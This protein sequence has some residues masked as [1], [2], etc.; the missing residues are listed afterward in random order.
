M[1]VVQRQS[2]GLWIRLLR[3][4][5]PSPTL[6]L[7]APVAQRIEHWTSDPSVAGSNPVG[8]RMIMSK[9]IFG[10]SPSFISP[11]FPN[12]NEE[13]KIKCI[14]KKSVE[15]KWLRACY[16]EKDFLRYAYFTRSE[17]NVFTC[18]VM[19]TN[20]KLTFWLEYLTSDGKTYYLDS[21][22]ENRAYPLWKNAFV[23]KSNLSLP[24]WVSESICYQI[25]PD[26]FF[27]AVP[28]LGVKTG[29]YEFNG[30]ICKQRNWDDEVLPYS[31]GRCLD[32]YNGDLYG[33]AEK[34]P[35]LKDLG[36]SC[37]YLN[38]IFCSLTTHRYDCT[39]YFNVDPKLGGNEAY[40]H[41]IEKM[42]ENGIRVIC[43]VSINHTGS[44]HP[45]FINA[46]SG[47][48]FSDFYCKNNDGSY[49]FWAG[50]ETLPQLNYN[51]RKLR[52]LIYRDADSV[53]KKYL[54]PPFCQD[55]WRM[56]VAN[57][58]G[59]TEHDFL[60]HEIW[61]EVR[62]QLKSLK[63]DV[64]IVAEDW[65]DS[66]V[67][68]DGTQWDGVMNYSGC[69]RP[70]RRWMGQRDVYVSEW[71]HVEYEQGFNAYEM[72]ESLNNSLSNLLPQMLF[73]QM[74]LI[75]SHDISRLYNHTRIF[76]CDLY[77]G[78]LMLQ[79]MLPGMPCIYYGDEIALS[80]P[81]GS[82]EDC[83]YPMEWSPD[84]QNKTFLSFYKKLAKVRNRYMDILKNGYF[85]VHALSDSVLIFSRYTDS[86]E[87]TLIMN[88]SETVIKL[89]LS[90][91]LFFGGKKA[92]DVMHDADIQNE[93][94]LEIRK[95]LIIYGNAE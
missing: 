64:Y 92:V 41:L 55:G 25:F 68:L 12:K 52:D 54:K 34:I 26:R 39:D 36:V 62:Q 95:S 57:E 79:Y 63:K 48:E 93:F 66:S 61:K 10:V 75:D 87:L 22:G 91:V 19:I 17:K 7:F 16:L 70:V 78:C 27:N 30:G 84:R 74:N 4:Q 14:C 82:N 46:L 47:G 13:V 45:W 31:E 2:P 59:N 15:L 6:F 89:K 5:I 94:E 65:E 83:R 21:S 29:D 81:V 67:F 18:S 44:K 77:F 35:Y 9:I 33:I 50:V 40:I 88:K 42:H 20:E 53:L 71:G 90:E 32:F 1:G 85:H 58:V 43:D 86:E 69:S 72:A 23:L 3:V 56:D 11:F 8:R 51:N 38:P 24:L 28:E 73:M 76:D 60:C 49:V 80:G 37:I